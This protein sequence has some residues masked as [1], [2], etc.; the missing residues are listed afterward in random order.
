MGFD[1]PVA[2]YH[3]RKHYLAQLRGLKGYRQKIVEFLVVPGNQLSPT[4]IANTVKISVP[5]MNT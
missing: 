4:G 5:T 1:K 2:D 3:A